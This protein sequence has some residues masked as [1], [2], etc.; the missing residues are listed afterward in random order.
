VNNPT[1]KMSNENIP[2]MFNLNSRSNL[3]RAQDAID[4]FMHKINPKDTKDQVMCKKKS[5]DLIQEW[6]AKVL[7]KLPKTD[8]IACRIHNSLNIFLEGIHANIIKNTLPISHVDDI[9]YKKW[10]ELIL[11]TEVDDLYNYGIS[12][13]RYIWDECMA[14]LSLRLYEERCAEIYLKYNDPLEWD[15]LLN[16][17]SDINFFYSNFLFTF[18]K[19]PESLGGFTREEFAQMNYKVTVIFQAHFMVKD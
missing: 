13:L 9:T 17:D 19:M 16:Q 18:D 6:G 4:M 11:T 1:S 14:R 5:N 7:T 2:D 15:K 10:F 8:L 3:V 12:C